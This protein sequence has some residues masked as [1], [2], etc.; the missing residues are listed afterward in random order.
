MQGQTKSQLQVSKYCPLIFHDGA[1]MIYLQCAL[2]R[3]SAISEGSNSSASVKSLNLTHDLGRGLGR[4]SMRPA[5]AVPEAGFTGV[6]VSPLPPVVDLGSIGRVRAERIPERVMAGLRRA[7]AQGKRLGRPRSQPAR[8]DVPGGSVRAVSYRPLF[9]GQS[10]LR[11]LGLEHADL[12]EH[13]GEIVDASLVNDAAVVER[14]DPDDRH[15]E[16]SAGWR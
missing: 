1:A 14:A 10:L 16:R 8:I 12:H 5:G 11:R 15:P 9:N 2:P 4:R 13:A 6:V 7:R 3:E